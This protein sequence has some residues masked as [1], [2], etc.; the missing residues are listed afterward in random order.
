[1][2]KSE[3]GNP[4]LFYIQELCRANPDWIKTEISYV[5]KYIEKSK[6]S[7]EK[8]NAQDILELYARKTKRIPNYQFPI[9]SHKLEDIELIC[10]RAVFLRDGKLVEDIDMKTL[11]KQC[12]WET[13]KEI[14]DTLG[15]IAQTTGCTVAVTVLLNDKLYIANA[16]GNINIV[17][18]S[19]LIFFFIISYLFIIFF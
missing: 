18:F 19:F 9:S 10:D 1:M 8:R 3:Y 16:G 11:L 17:L 5:E 12:F 14:C 6:D 15:D 13:D 4:S 2:I 7:Y